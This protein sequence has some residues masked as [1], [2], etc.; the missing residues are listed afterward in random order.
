MLYIN[1]VARG[2]NKMGIDQSDGAVFVAVGYLKNTNLM[3]LWLRLT[4][5]LS[6]PLN[7]SY[8]YSFHLQFQPS[9]NGIRG[10]PSHQVTDFILAHTIP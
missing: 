10:R 6:L 7:S 8:T 9:L 1:S 3:K 5:L 2:Q 4:T